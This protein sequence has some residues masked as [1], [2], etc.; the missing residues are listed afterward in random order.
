[1]TKV[2][3]L[4]ISW[5]GPRVKFTW[6]AKFER[7]VSAWWRARWMRVRLHKRARARLRECALYVIGLCAMYARRMR[8]QQV[9]SRGDWS[10][11]RASKRA[12]CLRMH[13]RAR[14]RT[15]SSELMLK[16][17]SASSASS[18]PLATA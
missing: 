2:C 18:L 10:C 11:V 5:W 17:G 8:M 9:V 15:G 4:V 12:R 14:G 6:L 13:A 3:V 7:A 16:L 1:M